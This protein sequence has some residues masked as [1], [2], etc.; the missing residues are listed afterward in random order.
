M[1]LPHIVSVKV[2]RATSFGVDWLGP[3]EERAGA[4]HD[5]RN[6]TSIIQ[7]IRFRP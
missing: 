7:S 5:Y 1:L 2:V 4:G 3:L 6:A